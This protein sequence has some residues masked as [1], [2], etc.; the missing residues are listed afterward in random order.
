MNAMPTTMNMQMPDMMRQMFQCMFSTMAQQ[1]P[2]ER[3]ANIDY[4]VNPSR[5]SKSTHMLEDVNAG[6]HRPLTLGDLDTEPEGKN[7]KN[8]HQGKIGDADCD[9]ESDDS[10]L[11]SAIDKSLIPDANPSAFVEKMAAMK[12]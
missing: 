10:D 2:R 1:R 6:R 11:S 5:R 3:D 7:D 12:L 9:Q 4:N 8:Q